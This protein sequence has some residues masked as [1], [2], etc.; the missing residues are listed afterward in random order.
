MK[1][2][3]DDG[4]TKLQLMNLLLHGQARTLFDAEYEVPD[5]EDP[6]DH[7]DA[8]AAA[9]QDAINLNNAYVA[10]A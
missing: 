1:N 5:P 4:G 2:I 6:E 10:I 9:G 7:A 3:T 8:D